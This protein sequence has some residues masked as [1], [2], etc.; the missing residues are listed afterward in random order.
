MRVLYT[1]FGSILL[2]GCFGVVAGQ[3]VVH[4]TGLTVKAGGIAYYLPAK[5]VGKIEDDPN[6]LSEAQF[7][8]ITVINT[9]AT[10]MDCAAIQETTETFLRIDDVIQDLFLKGDSHETVLYKTIANVIRCIHL[11]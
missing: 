5:P 10:S 6:S 7:R 11:S 1:S 8:A 9:N 3:S 2:V 4:T